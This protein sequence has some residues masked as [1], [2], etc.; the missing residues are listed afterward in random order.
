MKAFK[1]L[2]KI[3][4]DAIVGAITVAAIFLYSLFASDSVLDFMSR[5]V[6]MMLFA[7]A[8]NIILG[9]GGL[10]PLGMATYFGMGSYS[11]VLLCV[12]GGVAKP[13]AIVLAIAISMGISLFINLLC[14][15][16]NDDLTFAFVSMGINTLLFTMVY[17]IPYVG[18]DT[19]LTGNVRLAFANGARGNFYLSFGV[20]IVCIVLIY[21]F[22]HSPF[23]TVLKGSRENLERLTF[24][25][26]NTTNVRLCACMVSSFFVTVAGILYA[27]RNMGAFPVMFSTNTSTEGLIMCLIGGMYS[28]FGPILGAVIVTFISTQVSI[29]TNYYQFVLGAIIVLCVLFLQGGLLRDKAALDL[30]ER[31]KSKT[32]GA[33][34]K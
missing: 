29:V 28:F 34:K 31:K 27:M 24:V 1:A 9:F 18:S 25:G 3:K 20:C 17:K 19:G 2:S 8:L 26:M 12:R 22:F 13:L 33:A 5:M 14:L 16:A 11:Y 23:A 7:S 10:R 6:I 15:R 30:D 21:L 4:R 32:E